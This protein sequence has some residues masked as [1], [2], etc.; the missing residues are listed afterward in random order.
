MFSLF[1]NWAR[2]GRDGAAKR[3]WLLAHRE[4]TEL[5][6]LALS[7]AVPLGIA[8]IPANAVTAASVASGD[9]VMRFKQAFSCDADIGD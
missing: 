7:I 4:M 3:I 6:T 8:G 1:E 5:V 2:N 9:G